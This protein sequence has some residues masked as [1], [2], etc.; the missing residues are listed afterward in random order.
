MYAHL[1]RTLKF[2]QGELINVRRETS[3]LQENTGALR[4]LVSLYTN[5]HLSQ[6]VYRSSGCMLVSGFLPVAW[7]SKMSSIL[8]NLHEKITTSS[9]E[10]A[11]SFPWSWFMQDGQ[12][13]PK[14]AKCYGVWCVML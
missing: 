7:G 5:V 9:L 10:E 3:L 1:R 12:K 4:P 13:D 11:Y 8:L 14:F 6:A 2:A